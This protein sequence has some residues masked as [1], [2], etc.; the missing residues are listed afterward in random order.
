MDK[1]NRIP[2]ALTLIALLGTQL[3]CTQPGS[4]PTPDP[5]I[6]QIEKIKGGVQA[7]PETALAN[8]EPRLP[9]YNNDMVHV[10]D[11]GKAN[12]D[13]GYGLTFT[14][15][16]DT[17]G[18]GTNVS[19]AGTSRQAALKL[20]QGGLKGHNP[21]GD[22]TTVALPNNVNVVILGTSYFITYD[23]VQ[24]TVWVFNFDGTV[25][26]QLPSGETQPLSPGTLVEITAGKVTRV[27]TGVPFSVDDFDVSATRND[28]PIL[29][30]KEMLDGNPGIPVTGAT[31]TPTATQ[32]PTDLPTATE[33]PTLTPTATATQTPTATPTPV[34]CHLAKFVSDVTIPDGTTLNSYAYFTKT[35]RL[36][37]MGSCIWDASYRLVFVDG[38]SMSETKEFPWTAG[39]AGYGQSVDVSV[40]LIAPEAAGNYQGNFMILAPNGTYFGLGVENKSFWVRIA[41]N[42]P[43]QLPAV[44]AIVSPA[45]DGTLYCSY[46]NTLDWTVPYDDTGVVEYEVMLEKYAQVCY[47]WCSAF[48]TGSVFVAI[49]SLDVTNDLECGVSHRW[50]VRAKDRDG[51]WSDWSN[52][53]QF[54]VYSPIQ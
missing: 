36:K 14:L 3:F 39:T 31:D 20:S 19:Q 45:Q 47:S 27:Y 37:N 8:V 15:Y 35:W 13:F 33:T 12:L 32:T 1:M 30:V 4:A 2:V 9:V 21:A 51:A 53:T 17:V 26:Y 43:N 16:N 49:D 42:A 40:D 28:S 29:G 41:V 38:T 5:S 46:P 11:K 22:K 34:P 24:D 52:W 10:F 25:E 48:S 54:M 18:G 6:G 23:P 50:R 44:P 7:G